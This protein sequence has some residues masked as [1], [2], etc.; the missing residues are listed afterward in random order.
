MNPATNR[1]R[2]TLGIASLIASAALLMGASDGAWLHRVSA[3]DHNRA[4]PLTHDD[5][6]AQTA[7]AAGAQ[8]YTQNCA[9]CHGTDAMGRGN[10]PALISDRIAHATDGDLFWIITNGNAWKG[11]P[12]WQM[13]PEKQRWQL[14]TYLRSLN[15]ANSTAPEPA[16]DDS[17]TKSQTHP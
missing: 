6:S 17:N 11:M 15:L 7:A 2:K 5:Q 13:L 12:P 14:V 4:N 10:R 3:K 9:K 8:I 16:A 1:T